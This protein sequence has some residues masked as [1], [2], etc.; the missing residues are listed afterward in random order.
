MSTI[1]QL[2]LELGENFTLQADKQLRLRQRTESSTTIGS[3][4][5]VGILGDLQPELNSNFFLF[6]CS[7]SRFRL[8]EISMPW[9]SMGCRQIHLSH[10]TC[11]I[12]TRTVV[13][14]LARIA[15]SHSSRDTRGSRKN[16]VLLETTSPSFA[17]RL[18]P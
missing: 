8:Q 5:K 2:I 9:Q 6:S 12:S 7:G 1:T 16:C 18:M 3:R 11:R 4:I 15:Q 17:R 10:V 14:Q 13:A